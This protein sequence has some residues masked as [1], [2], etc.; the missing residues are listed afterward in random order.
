R[1]LL[2]RLVEPPRRRGARHLRRP[3]PHRGVAAGP[4]RQY[5]GSLPGV[6]ADSRTGLSQPSAKGSRTPSAQHG[7]SAM[8]DRSSQTAFQGASGLMTS[9]PAID[10]LT[11]SGAARFIFARSIFLIWLFS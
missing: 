6:G 2:R 4:P 9:A 1:D 7:R 8:I 11:M 3:L 10:I 5:S